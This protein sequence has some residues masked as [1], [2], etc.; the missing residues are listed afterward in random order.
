MKPLLT[1]ISLLAFLA[2][3]PASAVETS[4]L[5]VSGEAKVEVP[6][7]FVRIEAVI[8]A[9]DEQ[10]D[11]AKTDVDKRAR[12]TTQA[13]RQFGVVDADLTFSG[14]RVERNFVYDRNNNQTF[15]GYTVTRTVEI[16]L[17]KIED[18]E[19]LVQALVSAGIDELANVQSDVDDKSLLERSA[20][21]AAAKVAKRKAQAMAAGLDIKL[22]LPLEVSE[23]Q[24]M[25]VHDLRQRQLPAER[26]Q[27][28][29][30]AGSKRGIQD[31]MLF[32]PDDIEVRGVVWV[33]FS[34]LK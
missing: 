18:Y 17:R 29:M 30:V 23:N 24:L 2:C 10:A 4:F 21:E 34:I 32:V 13:I 8:T 15:T 9:K 16:R 14:V 22:G 19:Q 11:R 26:M 6:P 28:V 7:D 27:E 1:L 25:P 20:L 5:T 31:P 3:M 12:Q 33:R